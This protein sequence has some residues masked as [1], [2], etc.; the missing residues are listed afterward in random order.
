MSTPLTEAEYQDLLA[1]KSA[2][3]WTA[4]CDSVKRARG[5]QYP[6]DWYQRVIQARLP[7]KKATEWG[8]PEVGEI[9]IKAF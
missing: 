1:T 2:D 4:V 8:T 3:E 6:P 5:G 9:R 7:Q